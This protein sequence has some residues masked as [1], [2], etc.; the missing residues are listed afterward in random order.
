MIIPRKMP[1]QFQLS[2]SLLEE[3]VVAATTVDKSGND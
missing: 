2:R 3:D 1:G